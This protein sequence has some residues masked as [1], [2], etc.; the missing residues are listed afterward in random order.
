MSVSPAS[1]RVNADFRCTHPRS[2]PLLASCFEMSR[3]CLCVGVGEHWHCSQWEPAVPGLVPWRPRARDPCGKLHLLALKA[4]SP[5]GAAPRYSNQ[6]H[7]IPTRRPLRLSQRPLTLAVLTP[8][9]R[10]LRTKHQRF[11][12]GTSF[13]HLLRGR[14]SIVETLPWPRPGVTVHMRPLLTWRKWRPAGP[15]G[16]PLKLNRTLKTS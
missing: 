1:G 13:P 2:L 5:P 11:P 8:P 14:P 15:S 4:T 6:I 3:T 10:R 7:Q 16:R 12:L 9:Q